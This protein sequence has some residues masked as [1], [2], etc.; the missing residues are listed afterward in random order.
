MAHQM[1]LAFLYVHRCK[2]FLAIKECT[3][4]I[5]GCSCGTFLTLNQ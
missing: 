5:L 3:Q 2:Q 4:A 1:N